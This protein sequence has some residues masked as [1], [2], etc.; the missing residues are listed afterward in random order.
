MTFVCLVKGGQT[1]IVVTA[2]SFRRQGTCALKNASQLLTLFYAGVAERLRGSFREDP[3][4]KCRVVFK[5]TDNLRALDVPCPYYHDWSVQSDNEIFAPLSVPGCSLW[6]RPLIDREC[7]PITLGK[8]SPSD[9]PFGCLVTFKTL[10]PYQVPNFSVVFSAMSPLVT[11]DVEGLVA[12][13]LK[14]S[15]LR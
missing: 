2:M 4:H 1:L 10:Y 6:V 9:A 14:S 7:S 3:L 12:L 8:F 11:C 15:T 5:V 13:A